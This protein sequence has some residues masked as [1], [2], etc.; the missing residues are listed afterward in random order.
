MGREKKVGTFFELGGSG[1][2]EALTRCGFDFVI[3]DTEHGPFSVETTMQFIR[4]AELGGLTPYVR[5]GSTR[6]PDV[7][8]MLDIGARGLIVPN[9]RSAA[10][11][12][13]LV[14]HAKFAPIGQRGYC[15]TRTS[16]WGADAWAQDYFAYTKECND[17]VRV[18]PQCETPEALECIEEIAAIEG[19]DGIFVG[20]LDLSIGMGIPLQMDSPKLL[21]AIDRV[22][23]ACQKHGKESYIFCG[24][25]E[26]ARQMFAKGFDSV[27][28]SMDATFLQTAAKACAAACRP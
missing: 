1:V 18:V 28:C 8:R 11:V 16:A 12:R 9:I 25:P 20:P 27:A 24:T 5:I 4:T 15:P 21:A 22:L 2:M 26:R 23:A 19:V 7:L 17:R 3:I 10:E 6:R 13:E 14:R